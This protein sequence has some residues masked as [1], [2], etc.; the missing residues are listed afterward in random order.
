MKSSIVKF[1]LV[2]AV[3][4]WPISTVQA[5]EY[6][7]GVTFA[8]DYIWRGISQTRSDFA[9]QGA[10][11]F[12]SDFGFFLGVWGSNIGR[13]P[14]DTTAPSLELDLYGGIELALAENLGIRAQA[15][16]YTY[17]GI[18]SVDKKEL[19]FEEVSAEVK[20]PFVTVFAATSDNYLARGI[21]AVHAGV[22]FDF[23]LLAFNFLVGVE[24]T[25][26]EDAVG[27]TEYVVGTGQNANT[28][29][30]TDYQT[31]YAGLSYN[32]LG[33]KVEAITYRTEIDDR[34]DICGDTLCDQTFVVT[35]GRKF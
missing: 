5:Y 21:T 31:L 19:E 2:A 1:L 9:V 34:A 6:K 29:V 15:T 3:F 13:D 8:T 16:R 22:R 20:L 18:P 27:L 10:I 24:A 26:T 11:E 4:S 32:F 28:V 25:E 7:G 35:L 30:I 17:P 23:P 33:L 12:D 14:I